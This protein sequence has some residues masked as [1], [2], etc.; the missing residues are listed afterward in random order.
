MQERINNITERIKR[1]LF[2]YD[3]TIATIQA[4]INLRDSNIEL[5]D[6]VVAASNKKDYTKKQLKE[7]TL[8]KADKV[9]FENCLEKTLSRRNKLLENISTIF[10]RFNNHDVLEKIFIEKYLKEITPEEENNLKVKYPE[11]DE[12]IKIIDSLLITIYK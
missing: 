11:I 3:L 1:L 4:E 7:I 2:N 12:I 6:S 10:E 5:I 8:L 9:V